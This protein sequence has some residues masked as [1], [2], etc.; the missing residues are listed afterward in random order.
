MILRP[1]TVRHAYEVAPALAKDRPGFF[2]RG[3]ARSAM[4]D[5]G[6]EPT[7]TRSDILVCHEQ[8]AVWGLRYQVGPDPECV[9]LRC[10]RGA[11]LALVLDPTARDDAGASLR[12][13]PASR[14]GLYV[15]GGLA[16]GFQSLEDE[17]EIFFQASELARPEQDRTV[18]A[19][20]TSI[21]DAWPLPVAKRWAEQ[22]AYLSH[23]DRSES[24]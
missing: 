21:S 19:S 18:E 1:L 9:F 4:E 10:T 20:A 15:T 5:H 6:L 7:V 13:D 24:R 23:P 8:G 17:T 14:N 2:S 11:A 3:Y 22:R 16:Y 12:L